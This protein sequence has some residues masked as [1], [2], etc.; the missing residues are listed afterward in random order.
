MCM[1]KKF[2]RIAASAAWLDTGTEFL[3]W[4][5]VL[6]NVDTFKYLCVMLS[7]DVSDWPD[8]SWNLQI[9][10]SKWCQFSCLLGHA[11]ADTRTSGR[12]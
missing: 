10:R 3:V 5:Q 1:S 2:F 7:S 8:M 6:E 12:F 9:K 11:G 4:D